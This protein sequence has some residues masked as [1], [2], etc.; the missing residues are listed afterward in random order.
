MIGRG[1]LD[2]D[3]VM[4]SPSAAPKTGDII[5]AR[6][7]DDATIKTLRQEGAKIVLDPANEN[8]RSIEIGPSDDYA[9]LGVVCGVFRPFWEQEPAPSLPA[10]EPAIA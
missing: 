5:A 10:E 6:L 2:G 1:I 3:F 8:E 7:G 9:P 4:V